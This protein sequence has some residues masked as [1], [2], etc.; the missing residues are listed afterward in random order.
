MNEL[1]CSE[2][3]CPLDDESEDGLC[4]DC[5]AGM[6]TDYWDKLDKLELDHGFQVTESP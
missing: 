5:Y 4:P 3:G 6:D 1:F 2:C